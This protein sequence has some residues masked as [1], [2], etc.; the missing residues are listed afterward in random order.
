MSCLLRDFSCCR[1]SAIRNPQ[2]RDMFSLV[3]AKKLQIGGLLLLLGLLLAGCSGAVLPPTAPPPVVPPDA[4][5]VGWTSL[6]GPPGPVYALAAD[7]V[8]PQTLFAGTRQG[9]YNSTDGGAHWAATGWP[10]DAP[11]RVTA[12]L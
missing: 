4:A 3:R 2:L 7:E 11:G 1:Y 12:L 10:G 6:G 8:T 5:P 9:V